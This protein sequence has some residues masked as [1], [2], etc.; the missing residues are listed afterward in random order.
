MTQGHI[1]EEQSCKPKW[2]PPNPLLESIIAKYA[3]C[4]T[5][6]QVHDMGLQHLSDGDTTLADWSC[7][8]TCD[9]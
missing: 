7:E 6:S 9:V 5:L 3:E 1:L 4:M 8:V 2:F